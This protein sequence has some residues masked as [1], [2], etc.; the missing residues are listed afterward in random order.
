MLRKDLVMAILAKQDL[1]RVDRKGWWYSFT[2]TS[3]Q[4]K[5]P[6][7]VPSFGMHCAGSQPNSR[8]PWELF[9]RDGRQLFS[10]I[11]YFSELLVICGSLSTSHVCVCTQ[12]H[13]P[14]HLS[15]PFSL[16][17]SINLWHNIFAPHQ[18]GKNELQRSNW[19][20]RIKKMTSLQ[21]Q[22]WQ[23]TILSSAPLCDQPGTLSSPWPAACC[24]CFISFDHHLFYVTFHN[25]P[26]VYMC[27]AP[28]YFLKLLSM[29]TL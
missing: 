15:L 20:E 12:A 27:V 19:V 18:N 28:V 2:I 23:K 6:V 13:A 9:I 10:F 7:A 25:I 11:S 5:Q 3:F 24:P 14:T 4:G 26:R 16:N 22:T 29:F 8:R 1:G 21:T 17:S